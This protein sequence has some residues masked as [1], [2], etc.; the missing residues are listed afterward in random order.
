M[1][2]TVGHSEAPW[3]ARGFSVVGDRAEQAD[4]HCFLRVDDSDKLNG[5]MTL[6]VNGGSLGFSLS[7]SSGSRTDRVWTAHQNSAAP[8]KQSLGGSRSLELM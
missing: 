7:V 2:C 6:F 3:A 1:N 4:S 8:I 5:N